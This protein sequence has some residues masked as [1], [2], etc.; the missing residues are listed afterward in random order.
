MLPPVLGRRPRRGP[1]CLPRTRRLP[2]PRG[3]ADAFRRRFFSF[4][5]AA[6]A[7]YDLP[8]GRLLRPRAKPGPFPR[9]DF[10]MLDKTIRPPQRMFL[11]IIQDFPFFDKG[12]SPESGGGFPASGTGAFGNI[13]RGTR[14][15]PAP[16]K[17]V[18]KAPP[19]ISPAGLSA[20]RFAALRHPGPRQG[21]G[22]FPAGLYLSRGA[23][24]GGRGLGRGG[25]SGS[26]ASAGLSRTA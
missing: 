17:T 3:R 14:R 6:P 4:I 23:E 10:Q 16:P 2:A 20:R 13:P 7:F 8:P 22:N 21:R 11:I 5:P 12:I 25:R 19:G 18:R 1:A 9:P 24:A 26:G 15:R